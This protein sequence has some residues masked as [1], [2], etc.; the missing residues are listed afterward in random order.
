MGHQLVQASVHAAWP[1][2]DLIP[3]IYAE[4]RNSPLTANVEATKLNEI[5]FDLKRE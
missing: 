1:P 3:G 2:E 5:N 4:H